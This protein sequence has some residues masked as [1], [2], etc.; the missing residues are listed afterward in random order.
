MSRS[1]AGT[2]ENPGKRVGQK[3]GLN[4]SI[5]DQGWGIFRQPLEYKL[6]WNGAMLLVLL[7]NMF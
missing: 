4:R 3:A 1:A 5:L 2:K 7:A 6:E